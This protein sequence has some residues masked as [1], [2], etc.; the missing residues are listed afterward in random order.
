MLLANREHVGELWRLG[1]NS[2][3]FSRVPHAGCKAGDEAKGHGHVLKVVKRR[4]KLNLRGRVW[5]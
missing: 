3:G 4:K 2:L 5:F 1:I